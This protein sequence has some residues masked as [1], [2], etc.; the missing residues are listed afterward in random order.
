MHP[1]ARTSIEI[2]EQGQ[3]YLHNVSNANYT[4][5]VE[6]YFISSCGGH[7]RH[8]I[9]HFSAL[10][11]AGAS[12]KVNYDARARGSEIELH[13][14]KALKRLNDIAQWLGTLNDTQL[15]ATVEV[16]SE[17]SVSTQTIERTNSTLG[18]ELLFAGSHAIHHYSMI[19]IAARIQ[20]DNVDAVFGI[21]PATATYLRQ[22]S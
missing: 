18:R 11:T 21:A 16:S 6:P 22:H 3:A 13:P 9:D 19:A 15:R 10:Q 8:I 12:Q 1:I 4:Q 20:G 5:I 7:M 17:I 14:D 2:I